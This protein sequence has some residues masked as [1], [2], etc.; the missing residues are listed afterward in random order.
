MAIRLIYFFLEKTEY[1]KRRR[2][3]FF[4]LRNTKK[5]KEEISFFNSPV[6]TY[7]P[8][9]KV[10]YIGKKIAIKNVYFMMHTKYLKK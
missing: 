7:T 9:D 2:K 1:E 6:H 8:I 3:H 5:Y 10:F 4:F